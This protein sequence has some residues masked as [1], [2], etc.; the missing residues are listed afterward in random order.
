MQIIFVFA[1]YLY[2][3]GIISFK[4]MFTSKFSIANYCR[5]NFTWSVLTGAIRAH[6]SKI[7]RRIDWGFTNWH[8][9]NFLS[10]LMH[11]LYLNMFPID[12]IKRETNFHMALY[13]FIAFYQQQDSCK[14]HSCQMRS[15]ISY[16]QSHVI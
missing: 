7:L 11:K 4:E 1:R 14:F 12:N 16:N 8:V 9:K 10:D 13:W 15:N 3:F 5:Y 2:K 6:Y